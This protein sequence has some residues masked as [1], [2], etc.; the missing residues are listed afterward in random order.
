MSLPTWSLELHA[1]TIYSVDSL[2]RL[3]NLQSICQK[4]GVDKLAITDHNDVRAALQMARMYPIWVIPGIEVMTTHGELLAWYIKGPVPAGLTPQETI[5]R[6]RD[7]GAVIGVAHPFDR[8]RSGAW[9]LENLREIV[10]L[11]DAIEVFNS[12]CL[13]K[14]DN[15]KALAFARKHD[16]LMTCG[17]DAH[18][19][20]EYGRAVMQT[21]PFPNNA[22]GLRQALKEATCEGQLSRPGV[23][24][25]STFAKWAKRIRPSLQPE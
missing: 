10:E 25:S 2:I 22:D 21:N 13:H 15:D 19:P 11:V 8:Y 9:Q 1:H 24:L 3:D 18:T 14:E 20:R 4:R 6:L 12:R 23:H 7:Q 5:R 17:S 16:K